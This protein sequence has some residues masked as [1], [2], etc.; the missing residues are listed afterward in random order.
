M[1]TRRTAT[2]SILCVVGVVVLFAIFLRLFNPWVDKEE[3]ME[4]GFEKMDEYTAAFNDKKFDVM[5]YRVD[6]ETVAPRNL[7][8]RR[9]DNMEDARYSGNGFAGRMIVLCDTGTGQFIEPS[10]FQVLKEILEQ[11][12]VYFV[13]IG[14]LKY[15]MLKDA[16]IIDNLP[17][18]GTMSYLRYHSMTRGGAAPNIAAENSL[19]PL[20]IRRQITS[21]Q[22][23]VYSFIT[24]MATR[25]LY[26]N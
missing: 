9:I 25:E 2:I 18:E 16:G 6:P 21:D 7:V 23:A 15:G 1:W 8:A 14:D 10:E 19:I 12:N 20:S 5:F 22:L 11:N 24:E 4:R 3:N 13:Y 17:K 26:W